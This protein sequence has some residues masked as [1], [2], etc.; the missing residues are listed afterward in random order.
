[1]TR[2]LI[3]TAAILT[4][5]ATGTASAQ[6]PKD[7]KHAARTPSQAEEI[8]YPYDPAC[9]WG[10]V[11]DG[12]GMVVRCLTEPEAKTLL[13]ATTQPA[14]T[15]GAPTPGASPSAEKP[16]EPDP[17]SAQAV[18]AEVARVTAD[19]GKLPEAARK[20]SS[21]RDRFV[22][23]VEEHGGLSAKSG[24]VHVRFLV[25]ARGRAEGVSVSKRRAVSE[26]AARCIADVVDRRAVGV[27]EAPMVGA[28]AVVTLTRSGS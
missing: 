1:M 3:A 17:P 10:R 2:N 9:A 27:P 8:H 19:E 15:S 22:E 21:A 28:T 14:A 12:K 5:A 4:A 18:E 24:E 16:P 7:T 6:D 23:C 26:E 25:R 20:L 13:A 11:A